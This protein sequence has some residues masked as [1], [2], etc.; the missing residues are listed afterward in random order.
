[1][2]ENANAP[3]FTVYRGATFNPELKVWDNSS[4]ISKVT[5]GNLPYG[6]TASTFTAQTGK[7]E[8]HHTQHV[9]LQVQY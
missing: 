6:I 2:T 8:K 5:T 7:T 9:Y 4:V 3:I 1:M